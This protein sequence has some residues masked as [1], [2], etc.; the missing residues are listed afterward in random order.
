[1]KHNRFVLLALTSL[2]LVVSACSRTASTTEMPVVSGE[3]CK[4]D[5]IARIGDQGTRERFQSLCLRRGEFKPSQKRD[6]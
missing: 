5:R 6:W 4:A 1:M 2:T 3:N